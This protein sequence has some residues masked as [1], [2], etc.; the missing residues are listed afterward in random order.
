MMRKITFHYTTFPLQEDWQ[1]RKKI[2]VSNLNKGKIL[3]RKQILETVQA[4][5]VYILYHAVVLF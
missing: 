1:L 5:E 2:F 4:K 3:L